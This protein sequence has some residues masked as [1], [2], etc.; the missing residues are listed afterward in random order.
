MIDECLSIRCNII[1]KM[2]I[3]CR[4]GWLSVPFPHN[5]V[6]IKKALKD[7]GVSLNNRIDFFCFTQPK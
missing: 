7:K 1:P 6:H 5:F 2:Y 4:Y 3:S